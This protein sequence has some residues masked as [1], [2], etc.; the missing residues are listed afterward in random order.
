M[1]VALEF[2]RAVP[3]LKGKGRRP[4]EPEPGVEE[5][6]RKPIGNPARAQRLFARLGDFDQLESVAHREAHRVDVDDGAMAVDQA[7][8]RMR[9][10]PLVEFDQFRVNA[11]RR[12]GER[13]NVPVERPQAFVVVGGEHAAAAQ[14]IAVV[15]APGAVEAAAEPRQAL[16][17][18]DV[19]AG[20]GAV[21]DEE[22]RRGQRANAAAHE[23]GLRAAAHRRL[24][25]NRALASQARVLG[26]PVM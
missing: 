12:V 13:G 11:L 20:N 19:R 21:A 1:Q 6:R 25:G 9:L 23:I 24:P 14:H 5:R 18:R 10:D 2:D 8:L 26:L 3:G 7:R 16:V 22:R 17:D 4:Q 15:R